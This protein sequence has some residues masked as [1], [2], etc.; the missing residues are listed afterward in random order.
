MKKV[1][2]ANGTYQ[3]AYIIRRFLDIKGI[4]LIVLNDDEAFATYLTM[5]LGVGVFFA[6]ATKPDSFKVA[7]I[8]EADVFIALSEND[9]T[10]AI[11]CLVAKQIFK[12]KKTISVAKDPRNVEIFGHFG[13]DS[14]ISSTFIL[15]ERIKHETEVMDKLVSTMS[16]DNSKIVISEFRLENS[17]LSNMVL[18]D[19]GFPNF[20]NI[21]CIFRGNDTI[22]PS[23]KTVFQN[24]DRIVIVTAAKNQMKVLNFLH[25]FDN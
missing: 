15:F 18:K 22:I 3:A 2:I 13:I 14:V 4:K 11:S 23:G 10:N 1:V 25:Q 8:Y 6:D 5:S 7:G 16:I 17:K 21:A 19:I 9:I 24:F 20:A 12:V